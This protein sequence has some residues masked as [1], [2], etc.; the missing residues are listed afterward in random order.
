MRHSNMRRRVVA[1]L[2]AGGLASLAGAA[3]ARAQG[4]SIAGVACEVVSTT[5][6]LENRQPNFRATAARAEFAYLAPMQA[7]GDSI[8][9]YAAELGGATAEGVAAIKAALVRDADGT[10]AVEG[11]QIVWPY[12]V[13]SHDGQY[14]SIIQMAHDQGAAVGIA[15]AAGGATLGEIVFEKGAFDPNQPVVGF[16]AA[17]ATAIHE[18]LMRNEG[19]RV[20][21][22]AGGQVYSEIVPDT[23][24][25]RAF[26]E[27]KL[28]PAMD[29]ARR[30]DAEDPCLFTNPDDYLTGLEDCF[31][32]SACCTVIGL[33][34]DCWELATLRRFRDGYMQG[35]AQGRAD[36][37]RYYAEAPAIAARLLADPRGRRRLIGLY[38]RTI[39]PAV[40]LAR[41]GCNRAAYALYRRM[42]VD[43]LPGAAG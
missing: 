13:M 11:L 42:M 8:T 39:V 16:N 38:W 41:I 3:R 23:A 33:T 36:I 20:S 27:G 5:G 31:L 2:A 28:I 15:I 19:F 7:I 9:L 17:T 18:A 24:D 22:V 30:Q 32:T 35:F 6:D 37:S 43:L 4:T 12:T 1:A 14:Y 40:V 34:D 10:V 25:Y 26:I 21:L 29:E